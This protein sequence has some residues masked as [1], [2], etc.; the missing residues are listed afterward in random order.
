MTSKEEMVFHQ[1]GC[2]CGKVRFE[3][4]AP[5]GCFRKSLVPVLS[6]TPLTNSFSS[7]SSST[8]FDW[9]LLR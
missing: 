5:N 9:I 2:H 7:R 8:N 6:H 3:L 1:G 4:K